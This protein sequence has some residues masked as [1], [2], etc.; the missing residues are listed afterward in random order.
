MPQ[1]AR[2][3]GSA[4]VT[5]L[6]QLKAYALMGAVALVTFGCAAL[7]TAAIPQ[8]AA[9]ILGGWIVSLFIWARILRGRFLR[10]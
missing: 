4:S 5:R 1:T 2:P 9:A 3:G 7:L 6:D 8:H 10:A